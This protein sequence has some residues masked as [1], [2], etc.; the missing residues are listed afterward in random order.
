M[1]SFCFILSQK[2]AL[3]QENKMD[4]TPSVNLSRSK[5]KISDFSD[6]DVAEAKT[7][8]ENDNQSQKEQQKPAAKLEKRRQSQRLRDREKDMEKENEPPPP[9]KRKRDSSKKSNAEK[10]K[11]KLSS[12]STNDTATGTEASNSSSS[13][14]TKQNEANQPIANAGESNS[15]LD[16]GINAKCELT[17][18]VLGLFD[19]FQNNP[20]FNNRY[21]AKCTLCDEHE[22]RIKYTKGNNGNLKSHLERVCMS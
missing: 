7:A 3:K 13:S 8:D 22:D 10:T 9:K 18:L 19:D 1:L 5:W 17:R 20:R 4:G 15:G 11:S 14:H 12:K 2:I 6:S 16:C 21:S